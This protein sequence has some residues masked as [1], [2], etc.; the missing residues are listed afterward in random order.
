[1]A[2]PRSRPQLSLDSAHL[3]DDA[4]GIPEDHWSRLFYEHVYLSFDDSQFADLYEEGGRYPISPSFLA[5]LTLLQGM[6]GVSDRAAVENTIMRRD[7]RI[8]LGIESDYQGFDPSVLTRFRQRLRA[9]G[10]GAGDLRADAGADRGVG[11]AVGSA[12]AAG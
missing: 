6:F 5:C 1:M 12:S 9:G 11:V 7:W 8:A 4:A 10:D 3:Y 2:K